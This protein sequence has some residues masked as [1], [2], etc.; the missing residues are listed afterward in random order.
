MIKK[1][2]ADPEARR[3]E[4]EISG[5]I[6]KNE[7]LCLSSWSK[8]VI[9]YHLSSNGVQYLFKYPLFHNS[10]ILS[11]DNHVNKLATASYDGKII[12]WSIEFGLPMSEF[13]QKES[14]KL[15]FVDRSSEI[16]KTLK[17]VK[18]KK[19]V[20]EREKAV[21][22]VADYDDFLENNN[23]YANKIL[24]LH[25]RVINQQTAN[26]FSGGALGWVKVWSTHANGQML[27]QFN[28][29]HKEYDNITNFCVDKTEMLLFTGFISFHISKY[30]FLKHFLLPSLK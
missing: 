4:C 8:T 18:T 13:R 12:I 15:K 16:N 7:R 10:I 29:A 23:Y 21:E 9:V 1:F 24:F 5:I 19:V 25:T 20:R 14:I 3:E 17:A 27:A 30:N 28:A 26:L 2:K 6:H 22:P 11:M